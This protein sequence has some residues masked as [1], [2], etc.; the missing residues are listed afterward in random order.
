MY[1]VILILLICLIAICLIRIISDSRFLI[2]SIRFSM[3]ENLTKSIRDSKKELAILEEKKE[4]LKTNPRVQVVPQK[5]E[6]EGI[7]LNEL[8]EEVDLNVALD[9]LNKK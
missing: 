8:G 9:I 5:K 2:N 6:P 7:L 4:E 1:T 3:Y